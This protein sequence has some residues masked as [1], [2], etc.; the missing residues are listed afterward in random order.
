MRH[1]MEKHAEQIGKNI[2]AINFFFEMGRVK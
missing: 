2:F 1:F